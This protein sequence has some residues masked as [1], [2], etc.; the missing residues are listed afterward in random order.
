MKDKTIEDLV[1]MKPEDLPFLDRAKK[2]DEELKVLVDKWGVMPWCN[3]NYTAEG[4]NL[5]P[6]IKDLW[7]KPEEEKDKPLIA[8]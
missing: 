5:A 7:G 8:E 3:L 4:I 1:V 6:V 2:F